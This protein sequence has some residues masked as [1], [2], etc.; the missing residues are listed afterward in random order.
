MNKTPSVGVMLALMM[1]PQIVETIY[2]P[3]L[4]HIALAFNVASN[5]AAQTL[6]IYFSAFALGVVF[7]GVVADYLGRRCSMLLGLAVY[8]VAAVGAMQC[9]QF[10]TLLLMRSLSA[11]GAAVGSVVTQTML[12]DSYDGARLAKVFGLMGIGISLSPVIGL[13]FG[14]VLA[15]T[16]GHKA[17]FLFL[18]IMAIA[19]FLL[20]L[21]RL[22]ETKPAVKGNIHIVPLAKKMLA[23]RNIWIDGIMVACFNILLFSYYLLGP[24]LFDAMA[25]TSKQFGYSGLIL[26]I[27]TFAG[28]WLNKGLLAQGYESKLLVQLSAWGAIFGSIMVWLLQ[29]G[30]ALLA[31]MLLVVASFGVGIPNILSRALIEYKSQTGSAGALFGLLYY[32]LIGFGLSVVG[33]MQNLGAALFMSGLLLVIASL[34]RKN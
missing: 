34:V 7:W 13:M 27:G 20:C 32:L 31:P 1:F 23:D 8:G 4:P 26:A 19:L 30:V 29:D 24:F 3:A 10:E 6:S 16:G 25:Y 9:S 21:V 14:G 5:T 33:F 15:D 17:V 2:S 18:S 22:P 28:S 11:F 12:R